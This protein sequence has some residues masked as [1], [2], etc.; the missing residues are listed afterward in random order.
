[1]QRTTQPHAPPLNLLPTNFDPQSPTSDDGLTPT[2]TLD[3][4]WMK[5]DG[6]RPAD[7]Y[8]PTLDRVDDFDTVA[9]QPQDDRAT[10]GD[11]AFDCLMVRASYAGRRAE[12][13]K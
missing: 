7:S 3:L 9:I 1:M 2:L 6:R 8:M 10:A 13:G 4:L 11:V 12:I 5:I